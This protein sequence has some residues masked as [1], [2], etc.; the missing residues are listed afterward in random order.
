[1]TNVLCPSEVRIL[2]YFY[3]AAEPH[4]DSGD[5]VHDSSVASLIVKGLLERNQATYRSF[6]LTKRGNAYVKLLLMTPLPEPMDGFKNPW[7]GDIIQ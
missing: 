2:L 6:S 3:Y 4:P 5:S 1:M 7:N